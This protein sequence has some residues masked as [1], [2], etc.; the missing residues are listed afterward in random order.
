MIELIPARIIDEALKELL[1]TMQS[2]DEAVVSEFL[3]LFFFIFRTVTN[4]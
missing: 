4:I 3:F 2:R 1:K